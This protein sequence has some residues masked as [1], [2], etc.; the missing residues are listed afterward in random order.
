LMGGQIEA[1]SDIHCGSVFTVSLPVGDTDHIEQAAP[2]MAGEDAFARRRRPVV[3][4]VDDDPDAS[5]MVRSALKRNGINVVSVASGREALAITRSLRPAVMVLD[6]QLGDMTGWDVLAAL[7]A[8]PDHAELP[9]ILCTVTDPEQRTG[10][11][12]VIEHLTKPF[13]R[14]HL[15]RLVQRF[16]GGAKSSRLLVVDDDDFY[17]E[18]IATALREEGHHV[19]SASNGQRALSIMRERAPDLL[20]LDMVMPGMDGLAVVE[21]MRADQALA[22][23]PIML[24]TAADISPEVN[25]SLYERAVLLVRKGESDLADLVQQVH[26]LLDQLQMPMREVK[27]AT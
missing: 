23:V 8:D 12:G 25:R 5:E 27:E 6:I 9:V 10:V 14:D 17:R 18:K 3:L 24:V 1:T 13:D 4:V 21:A 7:R 19:E 11:L 15:N 2:P 22:L 16:V 26:H 20:L